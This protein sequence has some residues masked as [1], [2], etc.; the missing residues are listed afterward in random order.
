MARWSIVAPGNGAVGLAVRLGWEMV[1]NDRETPTAPQSTWHR[2][3]N[4]F[5]FVSQEFSESH[6]FWFCVLKFNVLGHFIHSGVSQC[7]G[8]SSYFIF[9]CILCPLVNFTSY[10]GSV[11]PPLPRPPFRIHTLV[12]IVS[13]CPPPITCIS[14][15]YFN[16]VCPLCRR[17]FLCNLFG[18]V[19]ML[20]WSADGPLPLDATPDFFPP[21]L[22]GR[23]VARLSSWASFGDRIRGLKEIFKYHRKDPV[24]AEKNRSYSSF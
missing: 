12:L 18:W 17:R 22:C 8:S 16:H 1:R 13:S 15:V 2:G 9:P 5:L 4:V 20:P 23:L 11:S 3:G 10:A 7:L 21:I 6:H 19:V 24:E 14:S